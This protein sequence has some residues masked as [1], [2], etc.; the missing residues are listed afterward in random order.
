MAIRKRRKT[1]R[2]RERIY[3]QRHRSGA[4]QSVAHNADRRDG[5]TREDIDEQLTIETMPE[6]TVLRNQSTN[7]RPTPLARC[8]KRNKTTRVPLT[9]QAF[10]K[11]VDRQIG[12]T[13]SLASDTPACFAKRKMI[14]HV[15]E[16]RDSPRNRQLGDFLLTVTCPET[17]VVVQ[18]WCRNIALNNEEAD[19]SAGPAG[20][21]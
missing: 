2:N 7:S 10:L 15:P 11:N 20:E 19:V 14:N 13:S 8:P 4:A 5:Y 16:D 9:P 6:M 18:R 17:R 3:H 12:W 21:P 1:R